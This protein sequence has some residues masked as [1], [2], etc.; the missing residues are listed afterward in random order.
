MRRGGG[1]GGPCAA[2][3]R[4]AAGVVRERVAPNGAAR[5]A[6]RSGQRAVRRSA[7]RACP[8]E[9]AGERRERRAG[10]G[11]E[12]RSSGVKHQPLVAPPAHQLIP[13]R[14]LFHGHRHGHRRGLGARFSDGYVMKFLCIPE[15]ANI[16]SIPRWSLFIPSGVRLSGI[17]FERFSVI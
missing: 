5:G 10:D 3:A 4:V 13:M 6:A 12:E 11:E 7:A 14:A 15:T 8:R 1:L 16:R 17:E 9:G 2:R